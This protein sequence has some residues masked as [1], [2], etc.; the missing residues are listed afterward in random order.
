MDAFFFFVLVRSKL[1]SVSYEGGWVHEY[2]EGKLPAGPA[3]LDV[4]SGLAMDALDNKISLSK[5]QLSLLLYV[6]L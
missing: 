4:A 1:T 2:I 3:Y 5:D 6:D